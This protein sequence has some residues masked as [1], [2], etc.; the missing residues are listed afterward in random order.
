VS[1]SSV[2]SCHG[3]SQLS[4]VNTDQLNDGFSVLIMKCLDETA[5]DIARR[6]R[7]LA[8]GVSDPSDAEAIRRYAD[9]LEQTGEVEQL[10]GSDPSRAR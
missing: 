4:G 10:Q 5:V 3:L 7:A 6:M 2:E 1:A 9:W 8:D